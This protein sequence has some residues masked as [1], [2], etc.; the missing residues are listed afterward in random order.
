MDYQA[1]KYIYQPANQPNAPTLLLLHGT[2]GNETDL[3][4]LAANFNQPLNVLSVRGNVSE[5]GMPRFF[6]RLGM[7]IFDEKDL[8]F[9]TAELVHFLTET[10]Q[11]ENFELNKIIALG[12]SNG[13]NIAGAVLVGYPELLAGA[14]VFRPMQPYQQ[15]PT[16]QSNGQPLLLTSGKFDST[17]NP[18]ATRG[19]VSALREGGYQAEHSELGTGHQLTQEDLALAVNWYHKNFGHGNV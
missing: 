13:A 5:H 6:K 19:Y 7:G 14:I 3:L 10:A 12:Y 1:L 17:V 18:T 16:F 4:S 15:L 8:S 9:R 2:G 11:K